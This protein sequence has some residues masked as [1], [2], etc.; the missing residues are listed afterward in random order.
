[1]KKQIQKLEEKIK[2]KK[3]KKLVE[4]KKLS[5]LHF[6]LNML[7]SSSISLESLLKLNDEKTVAK[8]MVTDDK[9]AQ[10]VG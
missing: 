9:S 6:K 10:M 1:F 4:N 2:G 3:D 8:A 5:S 7:R